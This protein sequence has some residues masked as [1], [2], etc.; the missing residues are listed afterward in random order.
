MAFRDYLRAHPDVARAYEAEKLRAAAL[1]PRD[2]LAYNAEKNDWI[3]RVQREALAWWPPGLA[4]ST[5][6]SPA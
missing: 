6:S 2:T 3:A 4:P 5:A 1:H